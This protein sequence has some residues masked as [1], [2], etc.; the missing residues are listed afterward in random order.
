[1]RL[2]TIVF[3]F[4][5]CGLLGCA[6]VLTAPM[7]TRLP[8]DAQAE[9]DNAWQNMFSPPTRLDRGLL[10]DT[11]LRHQLHQLGVDELRFVSKKH[12]GDA[13]V[14]MEVDYNRLDPSFDA[15]TVT[16]ISAPGLE[17]RRE[18]YTFEEIE[19]RMNFFWSVP[20]EQG[21]EPD[22][23]EHAQNVQAR[24]LEVKAATQPADSP[25]H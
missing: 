10:L 1:M 5:P 15:F 18:R 4:I 3:A 19:G 17:I 2:T 23:A 11:L 13:L 6:G 16:Y 7:V 20:A 21:T 22:L 12:V 9:V 24:L 8:D 14:V 25:N